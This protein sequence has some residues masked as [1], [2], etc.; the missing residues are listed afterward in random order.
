MIACVRR[1][2][3]FPG[4]FALGIAAVVA[5]LAPPGR[6]QTVVESYV[7]QGATPKPTP[8]TLGENSAQWDGVEAIFTYSGSDVLLRYF[9]RPSL[10]VF[11]IVGAIDGAL[12]D[13]TLGGTV[14]GGAGVLDSGSEAFDGESLR[15]TFDG[16]NYEVTY[17]L[18]QKTLA[19]TFDGSFHDLVPGR[20]RNRSA[21]SRSFYLPFSGKFGVA[22]SEFDGRRVFA[23]AFLDFVFSRAH[24]GI[25]L[26][27]LSTA[28]AESVDYAPRA[29]GTSTRE[30][31]YLTAS[32][33]IHEVFPGVPFRTGPGVEALAP[34]LFYGDWNGWQTRCNFSEGGTFADAAGRLRLLAAYRCDAICYVRHVW[35]KCAEENCSRPPLFPCDHA[36][37][38]GHP[39]C[40]S[41]LERLRPWSKFFGFTPAYGCERC[42]PDWPDVLPPDDAFGGTAGLVALSQT[43]RDLGYPFGLYSIYNPTYGTPAGQIVETASLWEPIIHDTFDTTLDLQDVAAAS[44][45]TTYESYEEYAALL[46]LSRTVHESPV[47]S[48]GGHGTTMLFAGIVDAVEGEFA[49]FNRNEEVHCDGDTCSHWTGRFSRN[50]VLDYAL[51]EVRPRMIH[52]GVGYESRFFRADSGNVTQWYSA[53]DLTEEQHDVKRAFQIAFAHAGGICAKYDVIEEEEFVKEYYLMQQLQVRYLGDSVRPTKIKYDDGSGAW[54]VLEGAIERGMAFRDG[55]I[56][57]HTQWDNGL[58]L[59]V[60]LRPEPLVVSLGEE[61]FEIPRWGWAARGPGAVSDF[62]CASSLVDGV[63]VDRVESD[64]YDFADG[65]GQPRWIGAIETDGAVIARPGASWV[66]LLPIAPGGAIRPATVLRVLPERWVDADPSGL[67]VMRIGARG[68]GLGPA[69]FRVVDGGVLEIDAA[70]LDRIARREPGSLDRAVFG[71]RVAAP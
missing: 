51:L 61:T 13:P 43:C 69:V 30:R 47:L 38:A 18:D 5:L 71:F 8:I 40:P 26:R 63:R 42:C 67:S 14:S 49:E 32:P 59:Y 37:G 68:E 70:E 22:F 41:H 16:G 23:T 12:F 53:L 56:R 4:A 20:F 27:Q 7:R 15:V 24:G 44:L 21:W 55:E 45:P 33:D 52:H 57:F 58:D 31:L 39:C 34:T 66:D 48:E 9:V 19:V 3:A 11:A 62:V 29:S 65:R 54:V 2:H 17:R 25:D 6:A 1:R 36:C 50:L 60:N 28:L 64:V 10:G 46:D 35:E